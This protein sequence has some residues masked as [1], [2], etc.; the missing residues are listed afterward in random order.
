MNKNDFS[1]NRNDKNLFK[2]LMLSE[3]DVAWLAGLLEGEGTFLL[4]NRSATRYEES[5]VPPS[6]VLRISM[7]DQDIIDRVA[8]MLDKK[9]F[10]A[11][12]KQLVVKQN[13]L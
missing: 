8:K 5:T 2:D 6:P 12:K 13:I 9:S 11:K 3:T 10:S 4:D 1:N 7:T